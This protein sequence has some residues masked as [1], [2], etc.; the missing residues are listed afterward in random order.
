[1]SRMKSIRRVLIAL[2]T[3]TTVIVFSAQAYFT[4]FQLHD[5][6]YQHIK[7]DLVTQ[8]EKEANQIYTPIR[9][10]ANAAENLA[11]LVGSMEEYNESIA[12]EF[13]KKLVVKN[14][15]FSGASL[16]FEP[17]MIHAEEPFYL[18]YI[19][20]GENNNA[21]IDWSYNNPNYFT[22]SWYKIGMRTTAKFDVSPPYQ[23]DR[24]IIWISVV[25]PI[26]R[27]HTTIG[28]ATADMIIDSLRDYV[29]QLKVGQ[30]GYA[31][32]ITSNGTYLGKDKDREQDLRRRISGEPED[33]VK[34]MEEVVFTS[35]TPGFIEL[36]DTEQLIAYAP[37][38][39][40]GFKVVLVYMKSEMLS[41]LYTALLANS[42][43]FILTIIFYI[44]ILTFVINRRMV[45]PLAK[46]AR[47]VH[48]VANG[49]LDSVQ[50]HYP[51][52]DEIG[53]VYHEFQEM[54][55]ALKV[56]RS[57]IESYTDS[58]ASK[59][60]EL[61]RFTYTV[62][63]DLRSPLITIKG[64]AGM[65]TKEIGK[66][67]YD[68]VPSD[69]ARIANATDQ[70]SELLNGLLELS[71]IGRIANLSE[72]IRMTELSVEIIE[73][74]H[75]AI[76]SKG[77][78]IQIQENMPTAFGDKHRIREV[79]Q[80]LVE[81]AVKFMDKANGE[82]KI[83]CLLIEEEQVYFVSDNGPGIHPDYHEKIFS[84]FDKLDHQA[85]GSGIGLAL[86]KRIIEYHHGRIWVDSK[87]SHGTSFLFT[88]K[89][90]IANKNM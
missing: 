16:A 33:E 81:N 4:L 74:L 1:V 52:H 24:G 5:F 41:V 71:R 20:K 56:A 19:Y 59:N 53:V 77:I 65:I 50:M 84:L 42:I 27:D 8:A 39:N 44:I 72:Q 9:D 83:G 61:E 55:V 11:A 15:L 45:N 29:V 6:I 38:G 73:L 64:F 32:L 54:I 10:N 82:V 86:V 68:R 46:L 34:R 14:D 12:F 60:A 62:S 18:S 48:R 26:I 69:L 67:R 28:V 79:L 35:S 23:D 58:L 30:N 36:K 89:D 85:E 76:Q 51:Y 3:A 47:L 87:L 31:Y 75:E 17:G 78:D 37:V 88:I 2:I 80:N 22:Q 49:N 90:K 7:M 63:H 70:M 13:M 57:D 40:T 43:G 66:G 21:Q 25:S